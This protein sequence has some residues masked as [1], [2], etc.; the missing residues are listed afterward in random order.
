MKVKAG[1]SHWTEGW[2]CLT[3]LSEAVKKVATNP[4]AKPPSELRKR[5]ARES[6]SWT[7]VC[8]VGMK[9]VVPGRKSAVFLWRP[10]PADGWGQR[11]YAHMRYV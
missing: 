5:R 7:E 2:W 1:R 3:L 4:A 9:L 8:A 6:C 10:P 11:I